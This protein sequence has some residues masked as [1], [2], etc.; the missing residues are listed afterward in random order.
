MLQNQFTASYDVSRAMG[1]GILLA[2]TEALMQIGNTPEPI[3]SKPA[4]TFFA[5]HRVKSPSLPL[6]KQLEKFTTLDLSISTSIIL[7]ESKLVNTTGE[8]NQLLLYVIN[9]IKPMMHHSP[10][11]V[12]MPVQSSEP[13][14]TAPWSA[15][16]ENLFKKK[17]L[18]IDMLQDASMTL[19]DKIEKHAQ[20]VFKHIYSVPYGLSRSA[21]NEP[22]I[23]RLIHGMMHVSRVAY[24]V[25][26]L[27]NFY[28]KYQDS[29]A[30]ALTEE[31]IKL[32]QI[33]ALF[34]DA[35]R[36]GEEADLWDKESALL[37]YYYLV[38]VLQINKRKA[39]LFAEAIANKEVLEEG[40]H[41][42][43]P[44]KSKKIV[45]EI[46]DLPKA[47]NIF[48][49]II[50]DADCLDIIRAR[51]HFDAEYLDLY[52]DIVCAPGN[53]Y[54]L[55]EMATLITEV[56]SLI[57]KQGDTRF[58]MKPATKAHYEHE[59]C[60]LSIEADITFPEYKILHQLYAD[61]RLLSVDTLRELPLVDNTPYDPSVALTQENMQALVREGRVLSRG[62]A[63][64]S[65]ERKKQS[66]SGVVETLAA[67]ELRKISR[68]KGIPTQSS[69]ANRCEKDGNPFRSTC[70]IGYGAAVFS[71]A[72]YLI[73]NPESKDIKQVSCVDADSG[74]SKKSQAL[75]SKAIPA[76]N[77]I[78]EQLR[79]LQEK[80]KKGGSSRNNSD[81][82][83]YVYRHSEVIYHVHD[84][85]AIYFTRDPSLANQV[86]Y[87]TPEIL[88][89][90][91]PVLEA[92]YL[93]Q[94]YKKIHGQTLPIFEYSGVHHYITLLP[95]ISQ[96]NIIAL[97]VEICSDYL[98]N[99]FATSRSGAIYTLSAEDIK[100]VSVY[101]TIQNKSIT[102]GKNT[103]ADSNYDE[104][105]RVEITQA[106]E[107]LIS[108]YKESIKIKL[109]EPGINVLLNQYFYPL[110]SDNA[111]I[112][113]AEKHIQE[114]VTELLKQSN[115]VLFIRDLPDYK[116]FIL[117]NFIQ[118]EPLV[119]FFNRPIF[120]PLP[121]MP[122]EDEGN[123]LLYQL[124][125]LRA[126]ALAKKAGL[127]D[128]IHAIQK[129]V[130]RFTEKLMAQG[131]I[132]ENPQQL[133][134]I[135]N[136][137]ATFNLSEK[138]Q[139]IVQCI[140][141]LSTV[142]KK[143]I[144]SLTVGLVEYS[145]DFVNYIDKNAL[146]TLEDKERLRHYL[147][148]WAKE[149]F[150]SKNDT[151]FNLAWYLRLAR[152]IDLPI[153]QCKAIVLR[154]L[155]ER[156]SLITQESHIFFRELGVGPLM[157]DADVFHAVVNHI[158]V[159][160]SE[161]FCA[162]NAL[163]TFH[164]IIASLQSAMPHQTFSEQ[165]LFAIKEALNLK[166]QEILMCINRNGYDHVIFYKLFYLIEHYLSIEKTIIPLKDVPCLKK[167]FQ[168]S[169][170]KIGEKTDAKLQ[171]RIHSILNVMGIPIKHITPVSISLCF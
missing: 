152:L 94:E 25:P 85:Q 57:D 27:A 68:K 67:V 65:A 103:A 144:S 33:T 119:H 69:K 105:L 79:G 106:I 165:Q 157:Q 125:I 164:K 75:R 87:Q 161:F 13:L 90:H 10:T 9:A 37:L 52:H 93:Q 121:T 159:S 56:R 134:C 2:L 81:N 108:E 20:W 6:A 39:A 58:L 89:P 64:P 29:E 83:P 77:E 149:P 168:D 107:K 170:A 126:Y 130:F 138:P 167:A 128:C 143:T 100:I 59:A 30:L 63:N 154:Q 117:C 148:E 54:A 22:K 43:V 45:W 78:N 34:H 158:D 71:N 160:L 137:Y 96:E 66:K 76:E 162:D 5:A 136:I 17:Q 86:A 16:I 51:D 48:Q 91:A 98:K 70:L 135:I 153:D 99:A 8:E 62:I 104:P 74:F 150:K 84:Y 133:R 151:N 72:G 41:K 15:Y 112:H 53:P 73:V 171:Q 82:K 169:W 49:K 155:N 47:K 95:E 40:Y 1:K 46:T 110:I 115:D 23:A 123:T 55:N 12:S 18:A 114:A 32:L 140:E 42:I 92:I 131:N 88:H 102:A 11:Q 21:K 109:L 141:N 97:W 19:E 36:E 145:I 113:L 35:A 44:Q 60:Y 38:R 3:T 26:V 124:D 127:L 147:S 61:G 163:E 156:G 116:P 166:C 142:A 118:K 7:L 28:R 80:L 120:D 139:L 31:D 50:H 129:I 122:A 14:R 24:Y 4:N 101:K 132:K 111:P 146:T